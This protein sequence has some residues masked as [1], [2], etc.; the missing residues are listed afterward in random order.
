[1]SHQIPLGLSDF[2]KLREND[3]YYVDKSLFI[4]EV[5]NRPTEV[6]L[7]PR[8][9]RFGKTLNLSM[10]RYFFE[11]REESLAHLFKGLFIEQDTD[12]MQH[13]GQYPVIFLTFKNCKET[14]AEQC[15]YLIR[16]QLKKLYLEYKTLLYEKLVSE[17]QQDYDKI[18]EEGG[19]LGN[20]EDALSFLMQIIH[21]QTGKRVIVLL[22]E[23]DTPIHAGHE[24]GYYE[25]I[26]VFMRNL[27][28][29]ALKDNVDLEKGVLTGIL[30]IA[31]ESI[32]SGL[33][34]L[35]VL[36]L[37]R[38]EFQDCFGFTETELK[39]LSEDFSL[40]DKQLAALKAWYNGYLFGDRVIYNPW[41]V[42][43]FIASSDR[44]PRPYWINTSSNAL[45]RD[46][47][48]HT[49]PGFQTQIESLLVGDSIQTPLNENI[50]LRDLTMRDEQDIWSL[51]V[52]SGYLKSES[53]GFS[54]DELIYDLTIPNREVRSFYRQTIRL[55]I[56]KTVGSQR[57]RDL[58]HSLTQADWKRF[59]KRLEEM[60]LSVLSYHDTAG[61]APE[62]VYHAFVLGLLTHLSDRYIVRSNRESGYGRY[63]VLM[64]PRQLDEPGFV[65]EFKKI[66]RPDEKTVKDAMQ[67]ALQQIKV[68]QYAVELQEQ[69]VKRIWGI[70]VVVDGKQVWVESVQLS[71]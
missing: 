53:V 15:L 29:G 37:L 61:D 33:N 22:D 24:Y 13:Q 21:R 20:W 10:L 58:L 46:L 23:Y 60:V 41:S 65:F 9:R 16:R 44:F 2:K 69:G 19:K 38:P 26:V 1:M 35:D 52:F 57:L 70:G 62:Q 30:R 14:T 34:N 43:N 6:L 67:S 28:S 36:P 63:D 27:L 3:S 8:P 25:E 17:E 51:L 39:Q 47:V 12:A 59:G 48:T 50:V 42:L 66:D 18:T 45:L 4:K 5:I 7:L 32:F 54:E 56:Q 55:W 71:D 68:K 49:E 64:I 11:K 31:K 40:T